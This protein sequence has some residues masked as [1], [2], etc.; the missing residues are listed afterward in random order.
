MLYVW[1]HLPRQSL[2]LER[3]PTSVKKRKGASK[4]RNRTHRG[5]TKAQRSQ[6]GREDTLTWVQPCLNIVSESYCVCVWFQTSFQH[7]ARRENSFYL[8][9]IMRY[10]MK[11]LKFLQSLWYKDKMKS[12][13]LRQHPSLPFP[14]FRG[15]EQ[16]LSRWRRQLAGFSYDL[17]Y[18]QS[19]ESFT[20]M[21]T[22][23]Q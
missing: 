9:F 8:L 6:P 19:S 12:S 5:D 17:T 3:T 13:Y 1:V 21:H 23:I 11:T 4:Q 18:T 16:L 22:Q 20:K 2:H 15:E 10:P 14:F 7:M